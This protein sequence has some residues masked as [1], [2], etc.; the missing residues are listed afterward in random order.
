ME[1]KFQTSF[2]PKQPINE[3]APKH[4]SAA[5]LFFLIAFIIFM[6]AIAAGG[7]VFIYTQIIENNIKTGTADLTK[8][9][10]AFDSNTIKEFTRLDSR[11]NSADTLLKQHKSVSTLFQVLSNTTLKNVRFTDFKYAASDDKISLSMRGEA[12]NYETVALQAKA[13]TDPIL[14]NVFKSPIFGDLTLD[15]QGNV[16]FSFSTGIDSFLVDYY[17]LKKEEYATYGTPGASQ[18]I[19]SNGGQE[20]GFIQTGT[21]VVKEIVPLGDEET[22]DVSSGANGA[23]NTAGNTTVNN[24]KTR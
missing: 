20:A 24:N 13:F 3:S 12:F 5:S 19:Q 16:A 15:Q 9:K 21:A 4:T 18:G 14:K 10:N 23:V 8:N 6:A 1:T 22:T 17:K 7:G 2:I 11:I